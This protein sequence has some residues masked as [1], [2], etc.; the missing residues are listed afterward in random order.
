MAGLL[1]D[2]TI[3]QF[4]QR[5]SGY[6]K[7]AVRLKPTVRGRSTLVPTAPLTFL[8]SPA[9]PSRFCTAVM[10]PLLVKLLT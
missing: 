4:L 6:Q 7:P 2:P 1:P 10:P 5:P 3:S 9:T 8:G